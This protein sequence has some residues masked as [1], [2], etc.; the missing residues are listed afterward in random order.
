MQSP[1]M[2]GARTSQLP[3]RQRPCFLMRFAARGY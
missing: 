1:L 2:T 3:G